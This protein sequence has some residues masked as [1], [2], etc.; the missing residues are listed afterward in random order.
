[1]KGDAGNGSD[2]PTIVRPKTMASEG[3]LLYEVLGALFSG[4]LLFFGLR[5]LGESPLRSAGAGLSAVLLGIVMFVGRRFQDWRAERTDTRLEI[6]PDRLEYRRGGKCKTCR[7]DDVIR[8]QHDDRLEEDRRTGETILWMRDGERFKLSAE[9]WPLGPLDQVLR[10][11]VTPRLLEDASLRSRRP[12]RSVAFL[13]QEARLPDAETTSEGGVLEESFDALEE[14]HTLLFRGPEWQRLL[15]MI[16]MV[17]FGVVTA[18]FWLG[19]LILADAPTL[20]VGLGM[21]ALVL[22]GGRLRSHGHGV[23]V[24]KERIEH[25]LGSGDVLEWSDVRCVYNDPGLLVQTIRLL[26]PEARCKVKLRSDLNNFHILRAILDEYLP[27]ETPWIEARWWQ[28]GR[29]GRLV[30]AFD[31]LRTGRGKHPWDSSGI[32]S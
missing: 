3:Y 17:F 5:L 12:S 29:V 18:I 14:A 8:F 9:Q 15:G 19:G 2:A 11:Q 13:P 20:A 26:D 4:I 28:I 16:L 21:F 32:D 22:L 23:F 27:A 31:R 10:D 25:V 6:W 30:D 24:T 1:M 7:F